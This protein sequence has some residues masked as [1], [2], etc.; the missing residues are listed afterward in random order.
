MNREQW[1]TEVASR[2]L[3]TRL[4]SCGT[5]PPKKWR[6]S[7]GFPKGSRGGKGGH[8]IGQC[9]AKEASGDGHIEMFI[10]PELTPFAAIE[11]L[12]HELVHACVGVQAGH[13]G[14]FKEVARKI[15]LVG[16]MKSTK[17]G[18]E[19]SLVITG[20]IRAMPAYPHAPLQLPEG[21]EKGPGSRL[22][23][24][25]C[26][27]CEYTLRGTRQWLEQGVPVCPNKECD[28]AGEEMFAEL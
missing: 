1:L 11:T 15:G 16:P 18:A 8:S 22:I 7:C 12:V 27:Q 19:L 24:I 14:K 9:W 13:R 17:A 6:V 28:S 4:T 21:K 20:I 25:F 5:K 23:K 10:S 2:H 26:P 3:L